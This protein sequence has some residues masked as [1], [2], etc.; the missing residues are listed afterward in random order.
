MSTSSHQQR[1]LQQQQPEHEIQED[2]RDQQMLES[3]EEGMEL[4]PD[5]AGRVAGQF[6]NAALA[7]LL[8]GQVATPGAAGVDL[9]EEESVELVEELGED[10][11]A[12][13]ELESRDFGGGGVPAAPA[14][15]GGGS[16][17][18]PW[19]VGHLF[20]GDD[21]DDDPNAPTSTG[22]LGPSPRR[23]IKRPTDDPF[24]ETLDEG[25]L[26]PEDINGVDKIIGPTKA[27]GETPRFGD[28]Q[29]AA[30]ET[31]LAEPRELGR[32]DLEPED[33]VGRHGATDPISRPT[34]IGSFIADSG[35]NRRARTVGRLLATGT[36]GL[37]SQSNGFSGGV[38]RLCS[39]A[40]CAE[41]LEGGGPRTDRAVALALA[42]DAWPT[43]VGCARPMAQ[44]GRLHAP[45]VLDAL[46]GS[47]APSQPVEQLP[48][49]SVLGGRALE[50]LLPP[51]YIPEV[52]EL[53]LDSDLPE[54]STDP[55]LQEIDAAL[56]FFL[57]GNNSN[58]RAPDRP[59]PK[60]VVQPA[61]HSARYLMNAAGKAHVEFAAAGFAVSSVRPDAPVRSPLEAAD[62][63]LARIA[64]AILRA[65]R[66]LEQVEG[67]P[68]TEVDPAAVQA[69]TEELNTAR[70]RL[71]ELR[72]WSFET[73]AGALD[74]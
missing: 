14:D 64:R 52:P 21:E 65:G 51:A 27:R 50:G 15:G 33:L 36:A 46:L 68:R 42:E 28:A 29:Y 44:K 43:T 45:E 66:K 47:R 60:S 37:F 35:R 31:C 7:A 63:A 4:A 69:M 10:I 30:V 39:L 40:V 11:E 18:D 19:D 1:R 3:L 58:R 55:D 32:R 12:G 53:D 25:E 38:A 13:Q 24:E 56:N 48:P 20:G 26:Q 22:R 5:Q 59:V 67:T 61:L 17:G 41:A 9:E 57:T 74:A 73:I 23:K 49:P 70:E 34:A 71:L 54:S 6:G 62:R 72:Q 2:A 8:G 16:S